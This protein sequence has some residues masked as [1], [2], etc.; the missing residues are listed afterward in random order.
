MRQEFS[1]V[2]TEINKLPKLLSIILVPTLLV[3]LIFYLIYGPKIA[4]AAVVVLATFA[5]AVLRI[6]GSFNDAILLISEGSPQEQERL[7]RI[8]SIAFTVGL[9]PTTFLLAVAFGPIGFHFTISET[10]SI[11][12]QIWWILAIIAVVGVL[13]AFFRKGRPVAPSNLKIAAGELLKAV[14]SNYG[15]NPERSL[16]TTRAFFRSSM[17]AFGVGAMLYAVGKFMLL[18]LST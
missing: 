5:S 11:L 1:A 15:G 7:D 9:I 8:G 18:L 6:S 14:A 13:R 4:L 3:V 2:R 16:R 10:L 17:A 12:G